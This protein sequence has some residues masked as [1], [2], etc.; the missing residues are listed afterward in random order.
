MT[1]L[2]RGELMKQLADLLIKGLIRP[3]V[4]PFGTP[5]IFVRQAQW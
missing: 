5:V 1:E 3:S 4:S 2:E